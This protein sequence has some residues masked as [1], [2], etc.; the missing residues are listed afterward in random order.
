MHASI[1]RK[2][3]APGEHIAVHIS[4]DNQTNARVKP[5]IELHQ[6]QI[7]NCGARL[8][9]IESV[10]NESPVSGTEVAPKS[11]AQ[12]VLSLAIAN[13]ESLSIRSDLITVKY[14]VN[15]TLDIPAAFNLHINL[16]IV[17]TAK[18]VLDQL[19]SDKK[20]PDMISSQY[21]PT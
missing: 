11:K 12:E 17:I 19:H 1:G 18:R 20:L 8:K 2:G 3:F 16:P 6:I 10:Q 5:Q 7:Y 15:V 9:T 21:T 4:V 13:D 14:F